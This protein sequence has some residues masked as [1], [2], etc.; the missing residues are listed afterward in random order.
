MLRD[1]LI[2]VL[3]GLALHHITKRAGGCG[4]NGGARVLMFPQAAAAGTSSGPCVKK[5]PAP[6]GDFSQSTGPGPIRY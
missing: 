5:S 1:I 2:G 3:V 6:L 4:C